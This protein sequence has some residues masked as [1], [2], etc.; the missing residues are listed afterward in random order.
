MSR[1]ALFGLFAVALALGACGRKGGLDAPPG[2]S[3]AIQTDEETG[4]QV[5]TG[6]SQESSQGGNV[7]GQSKTRLPRIQGVDRRIPL[8]AILN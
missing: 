4:Q 8:D 6:Q 7:V 1:F 3:A 5:L 2:G